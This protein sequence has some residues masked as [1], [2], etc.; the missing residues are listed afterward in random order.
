LKLQG[1]EPQALK[2][3]PKLDPKLLYYR[4]VFSELSDSRNYSQSGQ[5]MPIPISEYVSYCELFGISRQVERE[6]LFKLVRA[7]DRAFVQH[8]A[9]QIK[10]QLENDKKTAPAVV[11]K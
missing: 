3:R 9:K 1:I 5:P 4:A 7:Q 8:S 6:R 2:N 10:E 11:H